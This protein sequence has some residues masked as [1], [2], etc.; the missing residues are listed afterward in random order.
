MKRLG[1]LEPSTFRGF[2]NVGN[3]VFCEAAKQSEKG[4][5]EPKVRSV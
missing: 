2:E 1:C 4:Q 3:P 5:G